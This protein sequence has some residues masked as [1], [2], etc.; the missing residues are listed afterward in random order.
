VNQKSQIGQKQKKKEEPMTSAREMIERNTFF[1]AVRKL[2]KKNEF[3]YSV[4][5]PL[6]FRYRWHKEE[7]Q[8]EKYLVDG[9]WS[10]KISSLKNTASSERCFVIGNGP[11][12][13]LED[14]EKLMS[15][16]TFCSNRIY[17]VFNKTKWRPTYYGVV[18]PNLLSDI[19]KELADKT[20]ECNLTFFSWHERHYLPVETLSC[21]NVNLFF[22]KRHPYS[23]EIQIDRDIFEDASRCVFDGGTI[24]ISLIQLAAYMGFKKI[25]LLG[26][27]HNYSV[28]P[29]SSESDEKN[30]SE[31]IRKWEPPQHLRKNLDRYPRNTSAITENYRQLNLFMKKHGHTVINCTRGGMLEIFER[32]TL[33]EILGQ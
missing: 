20:S 9:N 3:L 6:V 5:S 12:L 13:M 25:Y 22:T 24:T 7:K 10:Q 15:E 23:R 18:D 14:L 16:V 31:I 17:G 29:Y 8:I 30:Y 33:E 27:D 32:K 1:Y 4:L 21:E 11:S 19:G 28:L 2:I 26:V